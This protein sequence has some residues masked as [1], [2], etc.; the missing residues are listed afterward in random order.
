[1]PPLLFAIVFASDCIAKPLTALLAFI[2]S[3]LDLY[4]DSSFDWSRGYPY[5]AFI[6]NM[7]Q[8]W[9]SAAGGN[10]RPSLGAPRARLLSCSL[11]HPLLGLRL[12]VAA[13]AMYNLVL[14][15]MVTKEELRGLKPIPKF[16]CVKAVVFFTFW[17]GRGTRTRTRTIPPC[18]VAQP[19]NDE[20]E[21]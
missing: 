7:S 16:L 10:W 21:S 4:G 2:L 20:S 8:I 18:I 3:L 19:I 13:Q 14:F 6:T 17:S 12:F 9:V 1:M 11:A 5:L 15:Y